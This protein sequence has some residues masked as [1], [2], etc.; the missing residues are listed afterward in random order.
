VVQA[1]EREEVGQV[2]PL[3]KLLDALGHHDGL[4]PFFPLS[5]TMNPTMAAATP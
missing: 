3:E 2:L 4:H 1:E 5:I